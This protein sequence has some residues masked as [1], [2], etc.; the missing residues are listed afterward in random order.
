MEVLEKYQTQFSLLE[1]QLNGQK[2]LFVH[3]I[4]RKAM[5]TFQKL[6][7][8]T[9]RQEAWKYTNLAPLFKEGYQ[10][11]VQT[12]E[13]PSVKE[14]YTFPDIEAHRLVFVDGVLDESQSEILEEVEGV[15]IRS[16]AKAIKEENPQVKQ[17]FNQ[18]AQT[19]SES[20]TALNTAF[21][22][23]GTFIHVPKGK[24]LSYPI[25]LTF[26]STD[27]QGNHISQPRNLI[28][29]EPNSQVQIIESFQNLCTDCK[30]FSN[31]VAEIVVQENATV[32]LYKLQVDENDYRHIGTMQVLQEKNSRF[33]AYTINLGGEL[34]R[35]NVNVALKGV[36]TETDLYG[37]SVLH[38]NDHV[39]N[40]LYIEHDAPHCYSNQLYKSLVD[41][42]AT[43]VFNG[44]VMVRPDA[45]KTNAFQSNKNI[46]LSD[47]ATANS[48][49][50]LEIYADDV[51]CSH[52]ATTG[53]L[54]ESVLFYIQARGIN[55]EM[56]K[57]MLN[58]AFAGEILEK[59]KIEPLKLYLIDLLAN[60]FE[61]D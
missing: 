55:K 27:L 39:D 6:G 11:A 50:E 15:Q 59:I 40:H 10:P 25:L 35:N 32:E 14:Y 1:E 17:W 51:K 18:L 52:G 33:R 24:I 20:L 22:Q 28:V 53:Q 49:P 56:A 12:K 30:A 36:N 29:A 5:Q 61:L 38:G 46:L 2:E 48:K 60:K 54:D 16:L 57:A 41:D 31:K 34:V 42:K 8:P 3:D 44:K 43:S 13:I 19:E 23:D 9:T 26:L 7:L 47:N 45:Q 4:R 37:L 58:Q 21:T